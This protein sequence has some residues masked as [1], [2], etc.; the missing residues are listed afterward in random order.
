MDSVRTECSREDSCPLALEPPPAERWKALPWLRWGQE[1]SGSPPAGWEEGCARALGDLSAPL[2]LHC[3]L[4]AAGRRA[5][6]WTAVRSPHPLALVISRK[7]VWFCATWAL[8]SPLHSWLLGTV[9]LCWNQRPLGSLV[10]NAGVTG[11]VPSRR[12]R[13][14]ARGRGWGSVSAG[15]RWLAQPSRLPQTQQ[16]PGGS[17]RPT[18]P[19]QSQGWPGCVS[20]VW[21]GAPCSLSPTRTLLGSAHFLS[22]RRSPRSVRP[23][24][25]RGSAL[26]MPPASSEVGADATT[27]PL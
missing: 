8:R 4:G 26:S 1:F 13:I 7:D 10:P 12:A 16:V 20:W 21:R 18:C 11:A 5:A 19:W 9:G 15:T 14:G 22:Q 23:A 27:V 2:L 25:C 24:W 6:A 3:P 17:P